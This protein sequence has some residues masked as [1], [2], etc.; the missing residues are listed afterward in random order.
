MIGKGS[1]VDNLLPK[2]LVLN[3]R[4]LFD[5]KI[6][7]D[8]FNE[9]FLNVKRNFASE[10]TQSQRPIEL[11]LKGSDSSFEEVLLSDEKI[12]TVFFATKTIN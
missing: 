8:S 12:K 1:F 4:N 9:Y 2:H 5:R 10:I 11:Y 7:V 6:I 3:N